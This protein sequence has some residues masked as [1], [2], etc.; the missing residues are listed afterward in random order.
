[1]KNAILNSPKVKAHK[2]DI[3]RILYE[4]DKQIST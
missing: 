1:M 3:I 2:Q 4:I